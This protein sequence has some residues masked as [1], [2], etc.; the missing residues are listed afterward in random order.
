VGAVGG[1]GLEA[2]EDKTIG[3]D[4]YFYQDNELNRL[5][6]WNKFIIVVPSITIREGVSRLFE[7]MSEHSA[8]HRAGDIVS[9]VYRLDAWD[10][11]TK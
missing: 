2:I 9:M 8:T 6:S 1:R 11:V 3:R 7:I 5:Y 10:V 4:I